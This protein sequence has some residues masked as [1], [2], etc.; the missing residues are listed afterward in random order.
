MQEGFAHGLKVFA[1]ADSDRALFLGGV[2]GCL[3]VCS[4]DL[5]V[6]LEEEAVDC[7]GTIGFATGGASGGNGTV[8]G[9]SKCC[10]IGSIL[11]DV[12]VDGTESCCCCGCDGSCGFGGCFGVCGTEEK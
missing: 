5:A 9:D 4:V 11:L 3:R 2:D 6:V 10:N 12:P 1:G 8:P 7:G